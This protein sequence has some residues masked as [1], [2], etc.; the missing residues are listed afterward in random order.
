MPDRIPVGYLEARVGVRS[1][2][3]FLIHASA[4]ETVDGATDS[5]V[6]GDYSEG[7]LYL[8]ATAL[9]GTSLSVAFKLQTKIGGV[10][11]DHSL[12]ITAVTVAAKQLLPVTNFGDEI[13]LSYDL[14][15][16]TTGITFSAN[17]LA[18]S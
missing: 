2:K 13:R 17:F 14:N 10:W 18:K 16:T 12:S 9:A 8:D 3:E 1:C 4:E 7:L 5:I 6:V 15:G 11:M